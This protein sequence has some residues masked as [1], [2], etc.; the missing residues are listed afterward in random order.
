MRLLE[1]ELKLKTLCVVFNILAKLW[2]NAEGHENNQK[3]WYSFSEN[4]SPAILTHYILP[5]ITYIVLV[6]WIDKQKQDDLRVLN[7][8]EGW[9]LPDMKT[10]GFNATYRPTL[11]QMKLKEFRERK[12]LLNPYSREQMVD[13]AS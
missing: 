13:G 11:K 8:Y 12:K 10:G 1:H 9:I 5:N 2:Y 6:L 4:K 7:F 3:W